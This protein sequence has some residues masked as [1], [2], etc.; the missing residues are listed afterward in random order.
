MPAVEVL[1]CY[2]DETFE[3]HLLAM[4]LRWEVAGAGERLWELP[5]GVTIVGPAPQRF[6]F[7][8]RRLDADA[9]SAR[10]LWD[11]T[12]LTWPSLSRR[13]LLGSALARVLAALGTDLWCLLDQPASRPGPPGRPRAA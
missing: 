6:G 8:V 4:C 9:Y 5:E 7:S 13:D 10:L 1:R 12:C 2:F 3:P 11:R